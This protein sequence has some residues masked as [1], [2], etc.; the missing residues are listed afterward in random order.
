MLSVC[1]CVVVDLEF[2][3]PGALHF[4]IWGWGFLCVGTRDVSRDDVVIDFL[5]LSLILVDVHICD[6]SMLIIDLFLLTSLRFNDLR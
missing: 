3:E 6:F 5:R 2:F 1:I 4:T